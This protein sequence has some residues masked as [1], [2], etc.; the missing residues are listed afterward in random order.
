MEHDP[1]HLNDFEV[2][3]VRSKFQL[4]GIRGGTLAPSVQ[5]QLVAEGRDIEEIDFEGTDLERKVTNS[6]TNGLIVREFMEESIK[7]SSGVLPGKSIFFAISK[8]HA[9]RLQELFDRMYPEH[10]GKLARVLVSDDRLLGQ[11]RV[12]QDAP[13]GARTRHSGAASGTPVPVAP[14]QAGGRPGGRARGHRL[15]GPR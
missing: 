15:Q 6:G 12:L 13:R 14:G 1:P 8:G 2:L 11:F 4:E 10:A 3:R 7:D 9:R 5:K